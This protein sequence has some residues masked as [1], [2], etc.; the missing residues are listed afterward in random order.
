MPEN[1]RSTG[2]LHLRPGA[3]PARRLPLF[4]SCGTGTCS[5]TF[6]ETSDPMSTAHDGLRPVA[7]W[8]RDAMSALLSVQWVRHCF[9]NPVVPADYPVPS[10]ARPRWLLHVQRRI[11]RGTYTAVMDVRDD[12][13]RILRTAVQYHSSTGAY[14]DPAVLACARECERAVRRVD[15]KFIRQNR[16]RTL[17]LRATA[18]IKRLM[19]DQE[20][21]KQR[22]MAR[23]QR[24]VAPRTVTDEDGVCG[25]DERVSDHVSGDDVSGYAPC[26]DEPNND[27]A[28][29]V[30]SS[31]PSAVCTASDGWLSCDDVVAPG[32][33]RAAGDA[34]SSS[35][36]E[37]VTDE[38]A[39]AVRDNPFLANDPK[40]VSAMGDT[41]TGAPVGDAPVASGGAGHVSMVASAEDAVP[42]G[43]ITSVMAHVQSD[44]NDES[45]P[46]GIGDDGDVMSVDTSDDSISEE[47]DEDVSAGSSDEDEAM[48]AECNDSITGRR[49]R[50]HG[51]T[52]TNAAP[53]MALC[54]DVRPIAPVADAIQATPS[55]YGESS[56]AVVSVA[57]DAKARVSEAVA[58]L[59]VCDEEELLE[60]GTIARGYALFTRVHYE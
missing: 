16:A 39:A 42:A 54:E 37:V 3:K 50:Y 2:R 35:N 43:S 7:S 34:S 27:T 56:N 5:G 11:E 13:Q 20:A 36:D 52:E 59:G 8:G 15:A 12:V 30:P 46:V 19:E 4:N 45:S 26:Y 21:Y 58:P 23:E 17:A 22:V 41:H 10:G 48:S 31:L 14:K 6:H 28:E 29:E 18:R 55:S 51:A 47:S 60:G 57:R 40:I 24:R 53:A 1:A 25:G 44:A 32:T 49:V 9:W 33:Q 38:A